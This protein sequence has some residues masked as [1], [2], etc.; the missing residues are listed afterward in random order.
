MSSSISSSDEP[1]AVG[2]SSFFARA[3]VLI[4][5]T[6]AV[7][8]ALGHSAVLLH[9][10]EPLVPSRSDLS[11]ADHLLVAFGNS[12][13]YSNIDFDE[14]AREL[15]KPG[16]DVKAID[17]T[18]GGWDSLHYYMLAL[19][20]KDVLRP[21]R[22]A[23]LIEVSPLSEDDNDSANHLGAIRPSVACRLAEV[24]GTPLETR[25]DILLGAVADLYRYRG[26]IQYEELAP[27]LEHLAVIVGRIL[28]LAGLEGPPEYS[29]AFK[30]ITVPGRKYV[31]KEIQGDVDEHLRDSRK[32]VLTKLQVLRFGGFKFSALEKA[33]RVLR[34]HNL[35]VYLVQTPTSRWL[36]EQV[37]RTE[38]GLRYRQEMPEL[39]RRTGAV[40][41]NDWPDTSFDQYRFSDDMHMFFGVNGMDYFTG[42]L[43]QQLNR[44]AFTDVRT[45]RG[46][47]EGS[48][49]NS[50][51][52]PGYI[53]NT[54]ATHQ[55]DSGSPLALAQGHGHTCYG[56]RWY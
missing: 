5:I 1:T 47:L 10:P 20:A 24:H 11:S 25:L 30:V 46:A 32:D 28:Q 40:L 2:R 48:L 36:R 39:A 21:G 27:R 56:D 22:D 38:G 52:R 41:I 17:F 50:R 43:A 37:N 53:G 35:A 26:S 6:I 4:T 16:D 44:Q 49:S 13:F 15:S 12:R 7:T 42:L 8:L 9:R 34:E 45:S 18:Y 23:V 54:S 31:V 14:L 29:P 19:L 55:T 33:V 3:L 51:C